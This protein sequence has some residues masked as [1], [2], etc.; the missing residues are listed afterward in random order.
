MQKR[1][2]RIGRLITVITVFSAMSTASAQQLDV[3]VAI[4]DTG[5]VLL[6]LSFGE[7]DNPSS[8]RVGNYTNFYVRLNDGAVEVR[9]P[10]SRSWVKDWRG[11]A[12]PSRR[13]FKVNSVKKVGKGKP[14]E[15]FLELTMFHTRIYAPVG[16][17]EALRAV[18]APVGR[19]D[20]AFRVSY[21]ALASRFFTGPLAS[22]S[23]DERLLLLKFAHITANGTTLGSEVFKGITYLTVSLPEEENVWNDLVVNRSKRVGKLIGAQ[24]PLLKAFAQISVSHQTIGGL[25][26]AQPSI[27]GTAPDYK[28][29]SADK[30]EAYF[31]MEAMLKFANADITSQQLVNQSIILVN[32]DRVEVDL[33]SQ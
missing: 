23:Q 29:V 11:V 16:Q 33:S 17:P 25:K 5:V 1:L 12:F 18:V 15:D 8:W 19:T 22:F 2:T 13:N 14:K 21:D 26:L 20:S 27:H 7:K 30:V 28:N 9:D 3:G 24:L 10:V 32:G 6:P 31:P 4:G